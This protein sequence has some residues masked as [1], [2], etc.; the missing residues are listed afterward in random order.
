QA[1]LRGKQVMAAMIAQC[2]EIAVLT[3][4]GPTVSEPKAPG[5]L[6]PSWWSGNELLGPFFAGMMEGT[7]GSALNVDGGELYSLRSAADFLSTYNWR[8]FSLP[9]D[10]VNCAFI[11]PA[12]R[13]SWAG[14]SSIGYGVYDRPFGGAPMDSTILRTTIANALR[15]ADRYV[16]FYTEGAT[17][18]RPASQGGAAAAW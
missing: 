10:A 6:F 4:H 12:L 1:R 5:P 13:P 9:S 3:L 14:K 8:K 17:F 16:W 2:P 15:Q 7:S 11:P 18:L